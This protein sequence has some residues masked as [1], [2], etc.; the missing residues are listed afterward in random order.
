MKSFHKCISLFAVA[1]LLMGSTRNLEAES[2]YYTGGCAYKEASCCPSLTPA[3]ALGAIAL[4]AIVAV[5]V[6]DSKNEHNHCHA[7]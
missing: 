2:C 4:V 7:D 6:Q 3:I 5:A 1:A